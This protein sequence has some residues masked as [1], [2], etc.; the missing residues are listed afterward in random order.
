MYH[1]FFQ[2][3]KLKSKLSREGVVLHLSDSL[4]TFMVLFVFDY[5]TLDFILLRD[6]N[7][8]RREL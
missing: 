2:N 6:F 4:D 3:V 8:K 5:K 1:S 7:T